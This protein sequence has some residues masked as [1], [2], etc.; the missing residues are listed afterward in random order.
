MLW[1][2]NLSVERYG[3][4]KFFDDVVYFGGEKVWGEECRVCK[5][6]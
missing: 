4:R 2:I 5:V 1:D 6:V 3:L